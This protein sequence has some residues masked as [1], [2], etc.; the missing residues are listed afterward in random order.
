MIDY[1]KKFNNILEQAQKDGYE[2]VNGKFVEV[3]QNMFP[4]MEMFLYDASVYEATG[5]Y[6]IFKRT[7]K[8]TE[9]DYNKVVSYCKKN[10]G[11]KV[12]MYYDCND[13]EFLDNVED[14]IGLYDCFENCSC[15]DYYDRNT[16][17][18]I[19]IRYNNYHK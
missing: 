17:G 3:G 6:H 12:H 13:R 8:I 4:V 18:T 7:Y 14:I 1:N 9:T 19:E 5:H 15:I 16:G 11:K 2:F 10:D